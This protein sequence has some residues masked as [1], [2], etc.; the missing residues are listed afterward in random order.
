[1]L[2]FTVTA[3]DVKH[4]KAFNEM[5][6]EAESFLIFKEKS[7]SFQEKTKA[8]RIWYTVDIW[9]DITSFYGYNPTLDKY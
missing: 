6:Q 1:M 7:A 4:L 5:V 9:F 8:D 3:L 2:R